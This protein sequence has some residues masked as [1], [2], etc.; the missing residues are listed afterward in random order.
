LRRDR[1]CRVPTDWRWSRFRPRLPRMRPRPAKPG[2][3]AIFG[4][5]VPVLAIT[6]PPCCV[7]LDLPR[8]VWSAFTGGRDH[9]QSRRHPAVTVSS[10]AGVPPRRGRQPGRPRN[11]V[12]IPTWPP[13]PRGGEAIRW[14][15]REARARARPGFRHES[16]TARQAAGSR[17]RSAERGAVLPIHWDVMTRRCSPP[18]PLLELSSPRLIWTVWTTP[19][20][21]LS[22]SG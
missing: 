15:A 17:A 5:Y 22:I 21:S 6:R 12:V 14:N 20:N 3:A 7:D 18:S 2:H 1:S 8:F 11:P 13:R 19:L 10:K 16:G 4:R 9:S